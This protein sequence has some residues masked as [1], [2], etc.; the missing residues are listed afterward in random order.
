MH[1]AQNS[2]QQQWTSLSTCPQPHEPLLVGWITG[3]SYP[4]TNDGT[5]KE[6]VMTWCP[7]LASQATACGM[8]HG[9]LLCQQ[10]QVCA[11][12]VTPS[13]MMPQ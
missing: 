13:L 10:C 8:D 1:T 2:C 7:P 12:H 3:A 11:M 6:K 5:D 4:M 9:V